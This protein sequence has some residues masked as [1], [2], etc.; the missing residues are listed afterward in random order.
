MLATV[1]AI[2]DQSLRTAPSMHHARSAIDGRFAA[3]ARAHELLTRV[4]WD[5]ATLGSTVRSAVEPFDQG[6]GR[7]VIAG[8]DISNTSSAVIA[9][10]M[11]LNELCTNTTKFGT[12][13]LPGGQV[14]LSWRIDGERLHFEW[15]ETGGPAV[16]EPTRKSFGTR[17]MTSLGH[18]LRG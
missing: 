12:L 13:S 8:G 2:T 14:R 3:L 17:M 18:Q 7:F 10:A 5:N 6:G 11:T 9:F 1:G 16:A 4:S 15:V